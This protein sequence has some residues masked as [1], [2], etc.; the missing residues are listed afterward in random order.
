MLSEILQCLLNYIARNMS[1]SKLQVTLLADEWK[2]S[3][4]G[5]STINREL[6]IHLAKHPNV[7]VTLFV[8]KCTEDDKIAGGNCNVRIVKAQERP[9]F[10]DP[11][12]WLSFP[13]ND[14]SIDIIIGHGV[15]LGKH[16]QI[17]RESHQC[18]WVQVVHTAPEQLS[19]LKT[20]S[21]CDNAISKG[22][23]KQWNEFRL[24]K[25]ADLVVAVGPR[26]QE[27][28]SRYLRRFK[29]DVFNL[30]P[31]IFSKLS[32]SELS[33]PVEGEMFNIL[34][35][36]RGDS[37]D[38]VLKGFDIAAKAVAQLNDTSYQ[39]VFVGAPSGNEKEVAEKLLEGGLRRK[40]LIVKE[41]LEDWED[42]ATE[43]SAADLAII[44]S[45]SEGFGLTALEALSVGLPFLVTQTS[46]FGKALQDALP[47]STPWVVDSEE[48][49]KWTEAI[50]SVRKKGRKA[51]VAECQTLRESYGKKYIWESQC[52][53]LVEKMISLVSGKQV[54]VYLLL[55]VRSCHSN[56]I[57][58]FGCKTIFIL[59]D[60]HCAA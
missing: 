9:G 60:F 46:G 13:P 16:A 50:K 21:D 44:P 18:K 2:S 38:F 53:A 6:A 42:L 12:D 26:L 8:P 25:I 48:S 28:Y 24:C 20:Y 55:I 3:K 45:R 36:G 29:K 35:F 4:G 47:Q 51:A 59:K 17:I 31:G 49:D 30:T 7:S 34:L 10:D 33:I 22:N 23:R 32:S 58:K 15:K 57:L 52:N 19:M 54:L 27:F 43:L 40:Q 39:L 11:V 37:E 5:L 56:S 14:L 41:F 1:N